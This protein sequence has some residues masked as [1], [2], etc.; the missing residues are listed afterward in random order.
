MLQT[1]ELLKKVRKLD[2][3]TRRMVDNVIGGAYH[4]VFKGR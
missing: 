2:I 3:V 1:S 4:S